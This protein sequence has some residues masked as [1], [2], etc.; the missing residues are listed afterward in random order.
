MFLKALTEQGRLSLSVRVPHY[1]WLSSGNLTEVV[2]GMKKA[3]ACRKG[4]VGWVVVNLLEW[5]QLER[6][7]ETQ[8]IYHGLHK[9]TD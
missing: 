3:Q 5:Y 8:C 6:N 4:G 1:A 2:T 7:R 9:E